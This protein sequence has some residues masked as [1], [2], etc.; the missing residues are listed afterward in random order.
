MYIPKTH[1]IINLT[2]KRFN[3]FIIQYCGLFTNQLLT[4]FYGHIINIRLIFI[5]IF[6]LY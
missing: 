4:L 1:N 2:H 3:K 5:I 6:F